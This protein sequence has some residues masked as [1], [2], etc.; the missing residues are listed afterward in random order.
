MFG[1]CISLLK[2]ANHLPEKAYICHDL[3][4]IF[5][6]WQLNIMANLKTKMSDMANLTEMRGK[7]FWQVL[8]K[9]ASLVLASG[10]VAN[11]FFGMYLVWQMY[12]LACI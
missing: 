11:I 1:N 10:Q 3:V 6:K 9:M 8:W 2:F 12:F 7:L 5:W 4:S